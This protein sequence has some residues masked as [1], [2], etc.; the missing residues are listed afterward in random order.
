MTDIP[1]APSGRAPDAA[2]VAL[3]LHAI[4]MGF[5]GLVGLVAAGALADL[6]AI[7]TTTV[8]LIGAGALVVGVVLAVLVGPRTWRTGL[9]V[10]GGL[11]IVL[12]GTLLGLAPSSP[13]GGG[14]TLLVVVA[15]LF[16]FLAMAEFAIRRSRD[17]P[18]GSPTHD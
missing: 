16:A 13:D 17:T 8:R 7:S 2:R 5:L 14:A 6:F 4:V 9:A 10:A 18:P 12:G 1:S 11:N 3:L 15:V